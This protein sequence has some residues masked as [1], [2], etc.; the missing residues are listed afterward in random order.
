M[1]SSKPAIQTILQFEK[2]MKLTSENLRCTLLITNREMTK[3]LPNL[4]RQSYCSGAEM[5]TQYEQ[6][7][8]VMKKM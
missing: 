1:L 7:S 6:F 2:F 4:F 3:I 5:E 8:V